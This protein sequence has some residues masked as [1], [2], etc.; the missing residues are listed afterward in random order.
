MDDV[1]L[2][3]LLGERSGGGHGVD[4]DTRAPVRLG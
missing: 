4:G 3:D 1:P 2:P